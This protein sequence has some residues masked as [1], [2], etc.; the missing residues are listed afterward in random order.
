MVQNKKL[1]A[2][3]KIRIIRDQLAGKYSIKEAAQRAGV[4]RTTFQS[5]K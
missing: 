2:R 3:E 4:T 5:W 1:E